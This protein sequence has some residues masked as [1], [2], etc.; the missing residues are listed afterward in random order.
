MQ[1]VTPLPSAPL[2]NYEH[3]FKVNDKSVGGSF[4]LQSKVSALCFGSREGLRPPLHT[5]SPLFPSGELAVKGLVD[6]CTPASKR[7][8]R[9]VPSVC[10]SSVGP[11]GLWPHSS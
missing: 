4:Y 6:G 1:A 8:P 2:Q 5:W 7:T 3:L 11:M 9:L 10:L